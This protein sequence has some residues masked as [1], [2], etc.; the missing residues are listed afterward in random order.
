MIDSAIAIGT[1]FGLGAVMGWALSRTWLRWLMDRDGHEHAGEPL[2]TA[3]AR[4]RARGE[5]Q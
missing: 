2:E 3:V 4:W 1:I 5:S